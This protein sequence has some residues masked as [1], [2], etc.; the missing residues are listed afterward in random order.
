M[1]VRKAILTTLASGYLILWVGGVGSHLL[2]G[3]TP[4]GN[5][6]AASAFLLLACL[7]VLL[8]SDRAD[9]FIVLM[10]GILGFAAE[11]I[12]VSTGI[13]FGR[14]EYT[15]LLQP[16]IIGVP[17][18]MG[19]AWIVLVAYVRAMLSR[20][21]LPVWLA[22]L[23][24]SIWMTALDMVIDPLASGDLKYWRWIDR[25]LYYGIPLQNFFGWFVVSWLIFSTLKLFPA[26]AGQAN[27][28][29]SSI[30]LS[31]LLFFTFIALAH[32]QVLVARIGGGLCFVHLAIAYWRK[33]SDR[34]WSSE[35][36]G[37]PRLSD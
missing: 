23:S 7:I 16:Q 13:P 9:R 20:F 21:R 28:W 15:D 35:R 19:V 12:G 6:W 8:A 17:V 33:G 3:R 18:V 29:P 2:F 36:N 32:H 27:H 26:R 31:I 5:N 1:N 25:G 24:A 10:V 4:D 34:Q 14:Y 11:I 22:T 37:I 30:G